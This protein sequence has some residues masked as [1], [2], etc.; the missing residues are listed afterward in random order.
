MAS[1]AEPVIVIF[2]IVESPKAMEPPPIPEP[3]DE[4]A[5]TVELKIAIHSTLD[6]RNVVVDELDP[7]PI[8]DP[9]FEA[10]E[11]FA[12]TNEFIISISAIVE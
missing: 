7:D 3:D 11:L 8:P 12:M 1:I 10:A 9:P 2:P 4:I 6:S 5:I